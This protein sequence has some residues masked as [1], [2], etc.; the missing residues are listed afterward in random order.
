M[1]SGDMDDGKPEEGAFILIDDSELY[2]KKFKE[3]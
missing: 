1:E 2:P 3:E